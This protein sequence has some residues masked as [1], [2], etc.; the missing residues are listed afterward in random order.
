MTAGVSDTGSFNNSELYD[1][2]TRKR[3]LASGMDH[4]RMYHAATALKS[5]KTLM[6]GGMRSET[7]ILNSAELYDLSTNV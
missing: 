1:S 4:D 5:G 7:D 3:T 2:S 6:V